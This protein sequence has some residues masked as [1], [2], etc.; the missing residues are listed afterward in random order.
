MGGR[1]DDESSIVRVVG[2]SSTGERRKGEMLT[3]LID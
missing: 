2:V 1:D 3:S